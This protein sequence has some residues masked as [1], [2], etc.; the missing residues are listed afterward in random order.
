VKA[1]VRQVWAIAL[2]DLKVE[3]RTRERIAA[4]GAFV[5]L[6]AI[7]LNYAVDRGIVHP[8]EIAA[9]L[10]WITLVLAGLLGLARTFE[11]EKQD[12]ALEGLLVA[13]VPRDALYLGKVLSNFVLLAVVV[14][15]TV[16]VFAFF[17]QM[18]IPGNPFLL[19]GVFLLGTAGFTALGTLFSAITAGSRMGETLLPVLLFPL[20]VPLVTFGASATANIMAGVPVEESMQG[21]RVLAAFTLVALAAGVVLFRFIVEE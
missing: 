1:Y 19:A 2:K 20:L 10:V 11:L 18:A 7:L 4:M 15:L 17:F 6:V 5:V 8:G 12:G 13:P 14:L 3:L 16:A 21:L 9:G